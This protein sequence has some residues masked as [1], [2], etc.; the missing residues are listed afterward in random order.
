MDS[1]ARAD[2]GQMLDSAIVEKGLRE[3]C[4]DLNFDLGTRI[5]QWHPNQDSRQGVFYREKH[6]CSMDR[7]MIP[8]FKIWETTKRVTE[9]PWYAAD[10]EDA[11]I[12]YVVI[13]KTM[14]GYQDMF[15]KALKNNDPEWMVKDGKLLKLKALGYAP[16]GRRCLR[17]GWRHT[18][19]ALLRDNVPG[20]TRQSLGEKF[21]VDMLKYPVGT[22]EE[23]VAALVEE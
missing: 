23:L 6:I 7:G 16:I 5:G 19:E 17:V 14:P 21:K 22:P 18:F 9:I 2:F 13:P 15:E 8:E 11:S 12:S 3:L 20:I 10:T 4:P 1:L